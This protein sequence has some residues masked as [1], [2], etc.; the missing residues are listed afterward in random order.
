MT[1]SIITATFN[2][3][4]TIETAIQSVLK[5]TYSDV[6]Y[7]IIDGKS[8]DKTL[9]IVSKYKSQIHKIISEPDK[10]IY[11]ALNKGI[12]AATGDIIGFLH[13]DD[14]LNSKNT[15]QQI[16]DSFEK[17]KC[18]A[19]YGDLVYVNNQYPDQVI[20]YWKSCDYTPSLLNKGWMPAHPTLYIR[21][22]IYNDIGLFKINYKI[23]ADYEFV[24]RFFSK[25]NYKSVYI[26]EVITKMRL[27]GES[28]KSLK[29]ILL[30]S[31]EDLHAMKQ[32]K[33]GGVFTLI[34]KN[35]S[36][37]PQFFKK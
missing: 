8:T 34:W 10:G 19:V 7:I 17:E 14:L 30:K 37:I 27:G 18:D 22:E 16:A 28:N 21:R 35:V 3:E 13:A 12:I 23:S 31:K 33:V 9:D 11:D 20:R 5:Q 26:P 6:E 1:I 36:K 4:Q 25:N 29:N 2:A 32:N 24:L 15:L